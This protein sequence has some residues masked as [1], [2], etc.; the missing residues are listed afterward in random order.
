M[1]R[2]EFITLIGGAAS[3]P[4][5][6]RAE[7]PL[8]VIGFLRNTSAGA[9]ANLVAAFRLGLNEVGYTEGQNVAIDFRWSDGRDDQLPILAA[10]LVRRPVTVLVAANITSLVAAKAATETIPIVFVTGDDPVELGFVGSLNRPASNITGISF[11][12]GTLGAKQ[13]ELLHELVPNATTV[14][15]LVNP[16]NPAAETQIKAA[17]SAARALNL[18]IAAA[19]ARDENE[20]EN[21]FAILTKQRVATLLM[22]GDAL[23]NSQRVRL[24]ALAAQ[25]ALPTIHFVR[26]FV[27]AGGLMVYGAS[28][29][30]AYRQVGAY[31]GRLL[32]GGK[33]SDLPVMLPTKFE[34]SINLRTAK[35]LGLTVPPTLLARADEVIE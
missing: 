7:H 6:A 9:S 14:G 29:P 25:H 12:S 18:E 30:D 8:P 4:L 3:W 2:R 20:F 15:M 34:L 33:P 17:Q 26:E 32:K 23:F 11:Y 19:H 27:T 21:A 5:A 1:R 28:I 22:G 16:N 24:A 13:V 31:A 35:A 10:A